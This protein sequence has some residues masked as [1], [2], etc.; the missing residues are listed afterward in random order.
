[1]I[2]LFL[3]KDGEPIGFAL[4]LPDVNQ[5]VRHANGRLFP[6]GLL[7]ILYHARH[8]HKVRV[9]V[10]GLLKEYR[11]RGLDVLL[12]LTL[13]RN[14]TRKGYY[15]GRVLLDPGG[16]HG[17]PQAAR[18]DRRE[19]VQDLSILRALDPIERRSVS[20]AAR[21]S[22]P[23]PP[24]SSAAT[25]S[26]GSS[27]GDIVSAFSCGGRAI[28][29]GS[30]GKPVELAVADLRDPAGSARRAQRRGRRPALRRPDQRAR[31][32]AEFLD[33]NAEGTASLASAFLERAPIDGIRS[34]SLLQQ[35]RGVRPGASRDARAVSSRAAIATRPGRSARTE[36]ASS[37]GSA[38]STSSA[39]ACER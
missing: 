21:S 32:N 1:M 15:G 35:P 38:V 36:R 14:G 19:G 26:T 17:D 20:G 4:A 11:G 5:A 37:Q 28:F 22:S 18:A 24:A 27:S 25:S 31:S 3:E 9:L 7:K 10:L 16:Q 12:Y 29:G 6:F 13:I 39:I 30:E 23:E 34:L 33:A 2:V 8:I